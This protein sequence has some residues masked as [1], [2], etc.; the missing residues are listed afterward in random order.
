MSNVG[1]HIRTRP[2]LNFAPVPEPELVP[3]SPVKSINR[4]YIYREQLETE[5]TRR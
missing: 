2:E 3:E 1:V 5:S 4:N